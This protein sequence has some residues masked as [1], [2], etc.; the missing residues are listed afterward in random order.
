MP[1][2]WIFFRPL[3]SESRGIHIKVLN[4]PMKKA[5]LAAAIFQSGSQT[6]S[7]CSYQ[8]C[9][10]FLEDQSTSQSRT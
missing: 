7:S 5:E 1:V 2:I 6:R 3:L 10:D 9:N 4:H 8:L